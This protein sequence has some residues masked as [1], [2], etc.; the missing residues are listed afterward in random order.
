MTKVKGNTKEFNPSNPS[1]FY[2]S[3]VIRREKP[4]RAS[5]ASVI[6]S[7]SEASID[8]KAKLQAIKKGGEEVPKE[9]CR[10]SGDIDSSQVKSP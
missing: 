7:P 3:E 1:D 5:Y 4:A 10:D 9:D 8:R 2:T 6:A